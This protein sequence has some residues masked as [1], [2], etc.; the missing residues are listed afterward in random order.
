MLEDRDPTIQLYSDDVLSDGVKT[1]VQLGMLN[2]AVIS[3][4]GGF[5]LAV[6]ETAIEPG[7]TT[8]DLFALCAF[9]TV[10]MFISPERSAYSYRTRPFAESFGNRNQYIAKLEGRIHSLENG[11][12]F[13]G[14]QSMF[15]WLSGVQ[16]LPLD[17]V[18]TEFNVS[19]PFWRASFGVDGVVTS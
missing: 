13:G 14:W 7:L 2:N 3:P 5:A 15:S 16:G 1:V 17:Q 8:P 11:E 4:A 10:L 18:L 12:L 6:G 19:A 9:H